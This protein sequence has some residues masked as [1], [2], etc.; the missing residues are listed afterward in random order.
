MLLAALGDLVDDIVVHLGGPV[1]LGSDTTSIIRRRRGGSAANFAATVAALGHQARFLGQVGD[2]AIGGV[3]VAELAATG[4]DVGSVQRAGT[5]G[6]I[7]VLVDDAG[8][9]HMLTDRGASVLL[10][11][12]DA[13]WLSGATVLHVPLYSFAAEPLSGAAAD[14]VEIAHTLGVPVSVDVSSTAL[15][16]SLGAAKV[17]DL[18]ATIEPTVVFANRDEARA[19]GEN[20]PAVAAHTLV[21][22]K[23]GADAA[24][25]LMPAR[26]PVAVPAVGVHGVVDTTGAGDAFAA[27]FLTSPGWQ[28][29]PVHACVAAHESAA[30]HL[31][32]LAAQ[33]DGV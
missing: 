16:E 19:L 24:Q 15:I 27:G 30:R 3:L 7:V 10:G 9:R 22:V 2:D 5:T 14:L 31:R 20:L 32:S 25:L 13:A 1:Q 18:L 12:V 17:A 33:A 23:A 6:S 4:V 8:E 28:G 29:D 21:V 26:S 11:H